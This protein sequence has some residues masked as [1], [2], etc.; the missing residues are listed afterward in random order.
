MADEFKHKRYYRAKH[1]DDSL[2]TFADT[3]DA[4]AK[5]AFK[6]AHDGNS[7]TATYALEDTNTTLVVTNEFANSTDQDNWK[8]A[9]DAL[10]VDGVSDP[11]KADHVDTADAN[12]AQLSKLYNASVIAARPEHFKTEYLHKNGSVSSTWNKA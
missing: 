4:I 5:M 2:A 10:W 7:V 12:N 8:T 11:H 6:A 3:D 1:A 9:V